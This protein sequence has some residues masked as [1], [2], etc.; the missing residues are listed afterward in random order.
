M[1]KYLEDGSQEH[2]LI[3]GR[4]L[5]IKQ[6]KNHFYIS[7]GVTYNSTTSMTKHLDGD[8]SGLIQWAVDISLERNDRL[9]HKRSATDGTTFHEA[10]HNFF[11]TGQVVEIPM[12]F[13]LLYDKILKPRSWANSEVFVINSDNRSGGTIDALEV[14]E[15]QSHMLR[16]WDWKTKQEESKYLKRRPILTDHAQISNYARAAHNMKSPSLDVAIDVANIAYICID[17]GNIFVEEVD[18]DR[19]YSL[20]NNAA[21][22]YH[23]TKDYRKETRVDQTIQQY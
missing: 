14:V 21:E 10:V 17:T 7:E 5:N 16:V 18:V 2:M 15:N 22:V 4:V 8:A 1:V 13:K 11:M 12:E 6:T 23:K 20:F 19:A 3:D 9:G